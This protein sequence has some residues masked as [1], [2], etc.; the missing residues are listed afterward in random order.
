MRQKY[1]LKN[2][3]GYTFLIALFVIVLISVLGLGLMF[4]TSNTLNITKHER[5]DQ[6]V[7]YIAEADLNVKR[8]E[9]NNELESVLIPFLNK[10]NNNANFDIEKDGDKIE[11]EYLELADEYLTQKINGLEVEKWAEVGKW[12]E[13][14][15]YEKQK[16]L[17]PSSQVTLIKDQPY[18]YTLK[19][20]A[21]IDG[22]SRTLSQTFTIKKPVKEKSEDEEVPPS[23][24]YNF[25]YGM[26]TNSFTT[27]NTL[28]TDAD[29]VSL[30][31]LTINNTGTLGK[32]IY[33][34]GAITFTNT[35]TINGDVIS[36]NN[37]IIKNGATFNKDIISKGN[38][39]AS[40]G[41]PRINGNIFS[42]GNINLKVGIDATKTD[43]FVYAHK[44]F[45]NEKGSDISGVIF[46]KESVKDSTNWATGLGRK[47]Y[48][49]GDIIYH[50]GDSTTNIKAENEE[51]FNQYLAS[52]NVDYNYYLNKLS[53]RHETP[54]NNNCENQSFVNAQIPELP[55][56][57][58]VDSSNFEKINDL[59]LSGGQAKIIT[60]T[61][62]SYIKNVSI[63]SNL[64]LTIDVGNQNRT[65]VIDHLNASNG[66]IQIKGTGKLN[67][68]VKN[69]LSIVNFSSN[70][71]SPFDT[72]VYYE[73]PSAINVSKKFE[74][75]LYVKNSAVSITSDGHISGNLLIASNKTMDVT[76]NTMFGNEDHHSVILVPNA[77][78]NFSGSSQI[79]GTII[80][81]KIDAVGSNTRHKFDKSKLNLDLFSPSEKQKYS[82][83]GDFINPDAP[84]ETS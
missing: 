38:I 63:N 16:G 68:L 7:F 29:I 6:S 79:F 42:M 3:H 35:S 83:D 34:K 46:G 18:T 9:I 69:D 71:R 44:N 74:S 54:N 70:E 77:S 82:T 65:L 15:N 27:T 56:F 4:I 45:L 49:M 80:G 21:K 19:S 23:T 2:E 67:L 32:N 28:N 55:P 47:R 40:G 11:K 17:Q 43:G 78:L 60:L 10:Y 64:T 58:N 37:I 73:G 48:S 51:K 84:I 5:N 14:T 30:N 31:D 41:S 75:N 22:T 20:E 62:N 50:K 72:T 33:A 81:N 66:H 24:N 59:S 12:A 39:I 36:L 8:A 25:C 76:G 1:L 13:V 53:D 61:N 57:L 26:L 52:E